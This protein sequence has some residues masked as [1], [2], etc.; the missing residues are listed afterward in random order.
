MDLIVGNYPVTLHN[1]R[2][3]SLEAIQRV[4]KRKSGA[5]PPLSRSVRSRA[6]THSSSLQC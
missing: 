3:K 5:K 2:Y 6:D 4:A 1:V